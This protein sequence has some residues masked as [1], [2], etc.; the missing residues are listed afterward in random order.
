MLATVLIATRNRARCL[1]RCLTSIERDTSR[2]DREIIVVDNGST[3]HTTEVLA[4]HDVVVLRL[5]KPGKCR[6]LNLGINAAR[7]EIILFTDDDVTVEPGW[8][9]AMAGAFADPTVDAVGGRVIPVLDGELPTWWTDHPMYGC[10]TLWDEGSEPFE[11]RRGRFPVGANMAFRAARLPSDPFDPR[12]GHTGRAS[13]GNDDWELFDRLIDTHTVLYE[14]RAVVNHWVD[15]SRLTFPA[16]RGKV[17]QIA[18]GAARQRNGEASLPTY[19]RRIV[20]ALRS[21]RA[22]V[23]ARRQT[24]R[25]GLNAA[26]AL[27]ELRTWQDAALQLETLFARAPGLSEWISTKV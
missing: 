14:P 11:M 25:V 15:S 19:P 6:A 8:V 9:D 10:V 21:M 27:A 24:Q 4:A 2:A 12:F 26:T 20:R 7:G 13:L 18:V 5:S 3:D 22:A 23:T 16:V 17:F 1:D